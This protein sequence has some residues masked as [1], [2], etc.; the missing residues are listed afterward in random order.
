MPAP[1]FTEELGEFTSVTV[2]GFSPRWRTR[3]IWTAADT[4]R[5][6]LRT[7][8]L[9]QVAA[10]A[11]GP[12]TVEDGPYQQVFTQWLCHPRLAWANRRLEVWK[13]QPH[14]RLTVRLNRLSSEDPEAFF[15]G[16]TLPCDG[17]LP[18][19]SCGG[20]PFVPFADQLPGTCR[21]YF[22]IDGWVEYCRPEGRW[23]WV[24]RDAPLVAFGGPQVLAKR[25][26]APRDVHRVLAMVFNNFWY[27]NFVGD[28]HGVMEFQFDLSWSPSDGP[29]AEQRAET[30]LSEPTVLIQPALAEDPRVI[31]RLYT[32]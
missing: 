8:M 7:Q 24:S 23:L 27:T 21:D 11:E 19:T 26:E 3:D 28:S 29:A 10:Q 31:H 2:S 22:A 4:K 30:L 16:C 12:A 13:H 5:D 1:L 32:P 18:Q 25:R 9:K 17:L 20:Q 15:I 6:E 14:A